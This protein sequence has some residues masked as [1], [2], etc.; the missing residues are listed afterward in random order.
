MNFFD[1]WNMKW[2]GE[3]SRDLGTT[4]YRALRSAKSA[5]LFASAERTP[6]P[7]RSPKRIWILATSSKLLTA[8]ARCWKLCR[9]KSLLK[10]EIVTLRLSRLSEC[11]RMITL[12]QY[13][14][15]DL[16]ILHQSD[17]TTAF[18][19]EARM[20]TLSISLSLSRC[21][22]ISTFLFWQRTRAG[23][24]WAPV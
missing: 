22:S 10:T 12:M 9:H 7:T 19:S 4:S 1:L 16:L 20:A 11:C 6:L 5:Q 13:Q 2:W 21:V 8:R 14:E 24:T 17:H 23:Y 18:P 15:K 3:W